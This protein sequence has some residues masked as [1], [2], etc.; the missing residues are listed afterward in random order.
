MLAPQLFDFAR[1]KETCI[2]KLKTEH[3][4]LGR[5]IQPFTEGYKQLEQIVLPPIQGL[6]ESMPSL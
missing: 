2:E 4:A 6:W 3:S 1:E 5:M